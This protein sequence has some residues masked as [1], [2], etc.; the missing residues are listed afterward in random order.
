MSGINQFTERAQRVLSYAAR[1][2]AN[3]K[4]PMIGTEHLLA[5]LLLVEDS[6][7]GTVLADLN[8]TIDAVRE[9]FPR[10]RELDAMH[11]MEEFAGED[12]KLS[13]AVQNVLRRAIMLCASANE[14]QVSTEFLL[15]A[16]LQSPESHAIRICERLGIRANQI[17]LHLDRIL[18]EG[19][20]PKRAA[21]PA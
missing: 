10:V 2:A 17:R 9:W 3:A 16:L 19:E 1:E 12:G 7:A 5:G 21:A 20:R 13:L 4:A 14:K 8:I 18:R 6:T 15:K 11:R